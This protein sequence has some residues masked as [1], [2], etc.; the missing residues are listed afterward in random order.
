MADSDGLD[1]QDRLLENG[2]S[3][4]DGGITTVQSRHGRKGNQSMALDVPAALVAC[5]APLSFGYSLG[6]SSPTIPQLRE[7]GLLDRS[8]QSWFGSLMSVGAVIGG[9]IAALC[10]GHLG[11]KST[12][13]CCTLPF[14]TGWLLTIVAWEKYMLFAGRIV[15]G[16]G[17][18]MASLVAPVY[19]AEVSP[20]RLRGLL[21]SCNQLSVTFGILVATSLGFVLN[22]KW[23]AV[24]GQIVA[25][26]LMLGML[27]MT[28]TPRW[29]LS[30]GHET[31]AMHALHW[32]RGGTV[33]IREERDEIQEKLRM[34]SGRV[35]LTDF[36]QPTL[37]HPL[38][39]SMTLMIFQQVGGINVV[40]FYST[41][42]FEK[43][44]IGNDP[45]VPAVIVAAVML[46]VTFIATLL[47]DILGRRVLL[48]VASTL[49]CLSSAS[50]GVY[51]YLLQELHTNHGWLS[52]VSVTVYVAAFS[53]GWGPIPWL[54]MGEVFPVR[55][56][57]LASGMA[58][59]LNWTLVFVITKEFDAMQSA[60]HTYGT[61]WFFASMCFLSGIFVA[62]FLPETKGK[63]LEEIE[64]LFDPSQRNQQINR[65]LISRDSE[66]NA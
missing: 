64:D 22:W 3:E 25:V 47:M 15:I 26:L 55:A 46:A 62:I 11:R 53:L 42:V 5:L 6:Y 51:Y 28:E 44:H 36:L 48:L 32:L 49:M 9:P 40:V 56:S 38:V 50:L 33:P 35:H 14:V 66:V 29:L 37:L 17:T 45:L 20:K 1:E 43:A 13:L 57:G 61:F 54:I 65:A 52:L 41:E 16:I 30:K 10:I 34:H 27:F 39:I 18:G 12:L 58:T 19:I 59:C 63:T 60:M 23:M 4:H 31:E 2:I 24:G 8:S 21:G 7:Y